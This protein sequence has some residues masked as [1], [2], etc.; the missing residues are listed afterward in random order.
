MEKITKT[1]IEVRSELQFCR[2]IPTICDRLAY[3][4][5]I[6]PTFQHSNGDDPNSTKNTIDKLRRSYSSNWYRPLAAKEYFTANIED[7]IR[8][9]QQTSSSSFVS[10]T[11]NKL[12]SQLVDGVDILVF[13][14]DIGEG[15]ADGTD[16]LMGVYERLVLRDAMFCKPHRET[17][18]QSMDAVDLIRNLLLGTFSSQE[19][20]TDFYRDQWLPLEPYVG[21]KI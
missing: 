1:N 11:L 14:I 5:A 7:F 4:A 20:A 2:H 13:P 15:K 21:E 9:R 8:Q 10:K 6:L 19:S 12:Y 17:G 16:D 3:V 18:Y